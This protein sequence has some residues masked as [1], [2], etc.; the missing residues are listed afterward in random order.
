MSGLV[1]RHIAFLEALRA[2]GLPVSLAEDLDAIA[3]LVARWTGTTARRS[4]PAYAATLVK[5]QSQRP[6]FDALF[7]LYFP[8]LV[9]E[10]VAAG[11]TSRSEEG[12]VRD[13]AA[14]AGRLPRRAARRAR[15]RRRAG[16]PAPGRRGGRAL[17]R[18]ARPRPGAVVAGRPTPRC[19]GSRRRSWSTQI[20]AGAAGARAAPRRRRGGS[21]AAGSAA[22]PGWSRTTPGAGSPRRRAP[23]TSPNVA[24]RPSID[25][26]DFTSA[27]KADLEEMRREIYPLARRLADPAHPGAPR[28]P[29]RAARLPAHRPRLDL[30]R[31]RPA[32]HPPPAEAAAPHRAGRPLRRQRLGRELRAVHAAAGL[33]AARPVPEG[34]R[35]HVHRPRPRG[36]PPLPAGRGRRRRD[37]RPRG[38]HRPRGAVGAHQLRPCVHEVRR[39][40]RRRARPEVV[41]ADPG[42]RPVQLQRPRGRRCCAELADSARHAWWLNPEH[43]RHW[44]TGDSAAGAYGE[45]VPMVECRNLTQLGEFVHDIL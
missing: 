34:A 28:A 31:R 9:G 16:A 41:A 35:V 11:R 23:T 29:P 3:A 2:A 19:S 22:S 1:D 18:D 12:A 8:R 5:K 14:G 4:A 43:T 15:R 20:V 33:R 42:R 30:H 39:G 37:G 45:V 7:D 10:G 26:L 13:N 36:H 17:R 21:P 24:V 38:Q 32:D 6:T 44:D 40:A 27:R 25:R